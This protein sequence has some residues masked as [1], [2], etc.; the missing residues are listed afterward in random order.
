LQADVSIPSA[1]G[2][3]GGLAHVVGAKR[4]DIPRELYVVDLLY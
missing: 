2:L 1:L 4:T 3:D